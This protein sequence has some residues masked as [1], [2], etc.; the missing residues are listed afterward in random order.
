MSRIL[1]NCCCGVFLLFSLFIVTQQAQAQAIGQRFPAPTRGGVSSGTAQSAPSSCESSLDEL[2]SRIDNLE[3][4]QANSESQI[5]ILFDAVLSVFGGA[6]PQDE[7]P[8]GCIGFDSAHN[9]ICG[10]LSFATCT[11]QG[12]GKCYYKNCSVTP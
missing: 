5:G 1:L 7:H 11:D 10:A 8:C 4:R 6:P 2:A 12:A 9:S 3:N